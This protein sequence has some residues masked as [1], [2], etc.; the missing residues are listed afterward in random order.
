MADREA[1][2]LLRCRLA[3]L[4]A[5]VAGI[6]AAQA[7][8]LDP[9]SA[10]RA[11]DRQDDEALDGI[12]RAALAEMENINAALARIEAGNYGICTSCGGPITANRLSAAPEAAL[13]IGCAA[14]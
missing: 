2:R 14:R 10:E 3:D 7:E 1:E 12:E 6:E 8:P 9:D 13:C 4:A 5:R 11:I